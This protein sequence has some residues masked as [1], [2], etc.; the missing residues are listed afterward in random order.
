MQRKFLYILILLVLG[1]CSCNADTS[2]EVPL[3]PTAPVITVS[4]AEAA[5]SVGNTATF[6]ALGGTGTYSWEVSQP[7]V[8]TINSSGVFTALQPGEATIICKDSE[9]LTGEA[10]ITV[11]KN[12]VR[13]SPDA[14]TI[15]HESTLSFTA[16]GGTTATYFWYCEPSSEFGT[17]SQ[18]GIFTSKKSNG[19]VNVYA[20]DGSNNTGSALLTIRGVSLTISPTSAVLHIGDILAFEATGGTEDYAWTSSDT[21]VGTVGTTGTSVT[22]T[23]VGVGITTITVTDGDGATAT[24]TVTIAAGVG[25]TVLV[26]PESVSVEKAETYQFTASG[27]TESFLWDI[28]TPYVGSIDGTGLFTAGK[29]SGTATITATDTGGSTGTATIAVVDSPVSISP[30]GASI[31]VNA[32]LKFIGT[33]GLGTYWWSTTDIDKATVSAQTAAAASTTLTA[34]ATGTITLYAVDENGNTGSAT[35]II[36]DTPISISPNG[37]TLAV[38]ATAVFVGTGGLGTYWWSSSDINTATVTA[39]TDTAATTEITAI[40]AGTA[41][42]YAV[43]D[44]GNVGSV[45]I[46]VN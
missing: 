20:V 12:L 29:N 40:A 18:Q 14:P 11:N 31:A 9:N 30:D 28:S 44:N 32:S 15:D 24:A 6:S 10:K 21:S 41:T 42:L 43:D 13:V 2:T 27:G 1:I 25:G 19:V 46:T 3:G 17:I 35:V 23:A 26:L 4:P 22:F 39:Q 8:G 37:A 45:T 7:D 38:D 16:S 5:V 33:G 36:A 34:I